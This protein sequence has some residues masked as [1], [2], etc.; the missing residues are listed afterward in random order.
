MSNSKDREIHRKLE[1]IA[2]MRPSQESTDRAMN[3]VRQQLLAQQHTIPVNH[4]GP[5]IISILSQSWLK[6]SVAA[7]ILIGLG[8]GILLF[9]TDK[10]PAPPAPLVLDR[11]VVPVDSIAPGSLVTPDNPIVAALT[12]EE[13]DAALARMDREV[14]NMNLPWLRDQLASPHE[15]IRLA[16][17]TYLGQMGDRQDVEALAPYPEALRVL[18]GRLN[19][20]SDAVANSTD[21]LPLAGGT[22][23]AQGC[24]SG[25]IRDALTSEP[26]PDATVEL[27]G[28]IIYQTLADCNG[29]YSF[30]DWIEPGTYRMAIDSV[31]FLTQRQDMPTVAIDPNVSLQH[32]FYLKRGCMVDVQVMDDQGN[33][34]PDAEVRLSWL[35]TEQANNVG[36][37]CLTDEQGRAIVGAAKPSDTPYQ[38]S[39]IHSQWPPAYTETLCTDA[40][41]V[42]SA[43]VV[44]TPGQTLRGTATY[45]D[46]TPAAGL[47]LYPVPTWWHNSSHVDYVVIDPNGTFALPHMIEGDYR[48]IAAYQYS[49]TTWPRREIGILEYPYDEDILTCT[50]PFES[51]NSQVDLAGSIEW[52]TEEQ[53]EE[54]YA[55]A[56]RVQGGIGIYAKQLVVEDNQFVMDQLKPGN[57]SLIVEG[58]HIRQTLFTDVTVP[59]SDMTLTLAC[60]PVPHVQ[61]KVVNS[62]TGLPITDFKV[63]L[64][65]LSDPQIP[66]RFLP[67]RHITPV[68][69]DQGRFDI[70]TQG[71]GIYRIQ[72]MAEGYLPLD[73]GQID[74]DEMSYTTVALIQGGTLSGQVT[75]SQGQAVN[76]ATV[77]LI[78]PASELTNGWTEQAELKTVTDQ[79]KFT[80]NPIPF[81]Q[82]RLEITHPDY[83][84]QILEAVEVTAEH[85]THL[86]I[87]LSS[88]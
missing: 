75:D 82:H 2:R 6:I 46:G 13:L 11:T 57:Y 29:F 21:S 59:Q 32:H 56:V 40:N 74:T 33:P 9:N 22:F 16:A 88:P 41:E 20:Q 63:S 5:R 37:P 54:V 28:P 85:P 24:L 60:E 78:I 71:P 15:P 39:V 87:T 8:L 69:H 67:D 84:T 36:Q 68:I 52:T 25:V 27:H 62:E 49:E 58:P 3:A 34:V 48:L 31:G 77:S 73:L 1:M 53:T 18:L 64:Q 23:V 72:I 61:G 14:A 86:E 19:P 51:P 81:G 38:I 70:T 79:G 66:L 43:A 17:A 26:V 44:M 10:Q 30:G 80:L 55:K 47:R 83:D 65:K 50:V 76:G 12:S 7:V 35:G 45:R 42:T 4:T